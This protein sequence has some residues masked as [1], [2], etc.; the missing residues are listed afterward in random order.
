ME[1]F[2]ATSSEKYVKIFWKPAHRRNQLS[3]FKDP[4][5]KLYF[6]LLMKYVPVK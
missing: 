5:M 6:L 3:I 2:L 1:N 4:K